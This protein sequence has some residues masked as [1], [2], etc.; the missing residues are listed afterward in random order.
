MVYGP[1][2]HGL[3]V[4]LRPPMK[5][6]G[7]QAIG[8]HLPTGLFAGLGQ[9]FEEPVAVGLVHEDFLAA[10]AAIHQVIDGTGLLDPARIKGGKKGKSVK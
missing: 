7:H 8:V 3:M 2:V 5:V 1:M 10:I 4:H 9:G 6:S